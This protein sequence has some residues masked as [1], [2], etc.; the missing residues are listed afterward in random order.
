[1][2]NGQKLFHNHARSALYNRCARKQYDATLTR[3]IYTLIN[4]YK[5]LSLLNYKRGGLDI[6]DGVGTLLHIRSN[7]CSLDKHPASP[8]SKDLFGRM[9]KP[10]FELKEHHVMAI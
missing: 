6:L 3:L 4:H 9:S 2:L 1:M 5:S 7:G 10:V 8:H